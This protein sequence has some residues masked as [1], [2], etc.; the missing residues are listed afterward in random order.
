MKTKPKLDMD[1]I[2]KVLGA[3]RR[4]EVRA[5][6]GHFGA[7][8]VVA[9]IQARFQ[10]P[11]GGGRSTDP[12]WTDRRLVP[13]APKTLAQLEHLSR[14]VS[15]TGGVT[16]SPLQ[17]AALLLEHATEEADNGTV[18]KLAKKRAS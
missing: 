5:G 18:T 4:G 16:V 1:K 14:V 9:E 13:L 15:E 2:A 8:Q 3:E 11:T 17:V 10:A 7:M 12:T 6:S